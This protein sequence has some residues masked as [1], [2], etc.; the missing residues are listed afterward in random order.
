ME[1]DATNKRL[2]ETV[3]QAFPLVEEP[4]RQLA[5]DV[6]ISA[7]E[8]LKRVVD[9]KARRII[10]EIGAIFD[11]RALGYQTTLVAASVP[12]A[13]LEAAA[14][15]ISQHPGVSHNYAREHRYNL[16]FTLA[17]PPGE[18]LKEASEKLAYRA[19]ADS[20]MVLPAVSIFKIGAFFHLSD[21][22]EITVEAGGN[23]CHPPG[24]AAPPVLTAK[25]IAVIRELQQDLPL[26]HRPFQAM[27]ERLGV[28]EKGVIDHAKD[29]L[30]RGL[31]RRFAALLYHRRLGFLANGMGCWR[32]PEGRLEEVGKALAA[33]PQVTHCY[34]RV[35]Y[36]QWP[37]NLF[38]MVHAPN[39]DAC[40]STVR[41]MAEKVDITDYLVLFSS[42]EFKKAMVK[43]YW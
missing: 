42:R 16:W 17:L 38:T 29:F 12:S 5:Q 15:V 26:V 30:A 24:Q 13:R 19:G 1:L 8:A 14:D 27:A 2:L 40:L 7:E 36:P 4:F 23:G 22:E 20:V 39:Q 28:G 32:V 41:A 21:Q 43:F 35:T 10:R 18:D 9:L 33:F 37:Y 11:S 6:G 25:D 3:Q 34:Q 31:M